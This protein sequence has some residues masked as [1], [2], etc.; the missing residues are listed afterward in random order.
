MQ[1]QRLTLASAPFYDELPVPYNTR[2][3]DGMKKLSVFLLCIAL[4]APLSAQ[5]R[6]SATSPSDAAKQVVRPEA[7]RAHIRFLSDELLEGR[8][9]ATRGYD[10]AARYVASQFEQLGL[11]P[12]GKDGTYYQAVPLRKLEIVPEE[13][14]FTLVRDGKEQ[15]LRYGEE[16]MAPGNES[17]TDAQVEAPL[18]FVGYGVTAPDQKYDDYAGIDVEGKIVVFLYGAPPTFSSTVRAHY[19]SSILKSANA[20]D[21]GAVGMLMVQT[22][23]LE[24][25]APWPWLLRQIRMPGFRW[26]DPKGMP[27]DARPQLRARG[28]LSRS[29]AEA[30]FAGAPKS[31]EQVFAESKKGKPASF[32]LPGTAR[33]RTVTR[34]TATESPNVVAT[35]RGS[36]DK[37]RDEYVVYTAHLDHL[38]KGEPIKGKSV[39]PGAFD[40]ASGTAAL[41]EVARA[42]TALNTPPRRSIVFV[43]VT[44]EEKGL[45]GSDY[46]ARYP[47]ISERQIVANINMDGAAI[48][49]PM[50]DVVAFGA[51]HSSLG[52]IAEREAARMNVKLSPDPQ[53]QEV[54]FI[55]SDQYSFVRRGIPALFLFPGVDSG[56]SKRT[57]TAILQDW[58]LT[59]YHTPQDDFEQPL[60]Y[61][62]GAQYTRLNFAIGLTVAQQ[63]ARPQWNQGDFFGKTYGRKPASAGAP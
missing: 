55:R 52:P 39:Y 57:G 37:L 54:F 41:I 28:S 47:T 10:L 4:V 34:H 60:D 31:L 61:N 13:C 15:V 17:A 46:Y 25:T 48:L 24:Q 33:I 63:T 9:T 18:V 38:G 56:N 32:A 35:L 5:T 3:E 30:L 26:L 2:P 58:I 53:P 40:N 43:A 51:E 14:S 11:S 29:G 36:D 22:P 19:S 6:K 1:E 59:R 21:R 62:A 27:N 20:Q 49:Y 45:L 50:R 42:F 8:G 44:G 23:D 16:Y 7:I 12:G